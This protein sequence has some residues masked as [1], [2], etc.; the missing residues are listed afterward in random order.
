M[1]ISLSKGIN[2]L[3]P[4]VTE[5]LQRSTT[6]SEWVAAE[7]RNKQIGHQTS[8]PPIPVR[9]G[10]DEN[11]FVMQPNCDLVGCENRLIHPVFGV[12]QETPEANVDLRL[13]YSDVLICSSGGSSP[14]P[15][16]T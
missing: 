9:E 15:N 14:R 8:V 11:E 10:M 12:P 3:I 16:V 1:T 13:I 4:E 6:P 5:I 2:V 7:L